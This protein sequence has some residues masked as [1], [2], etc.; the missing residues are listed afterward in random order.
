MRVHGALQIFGA[1]A[2][3]H[4][5]HGLGDQLAGHRTDDVHAQ[6]LVAG[7]RGDEFHESR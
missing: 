2:K 1:A 7:F 6:Y 3:F 5:Q 4:R